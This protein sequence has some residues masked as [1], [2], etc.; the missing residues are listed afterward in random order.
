[1]PED[2]NA[3]IEKI[4]TEGVDAAKESAAK[5][6]AEAKNQ[7]RRILEKA[8][9]DAESVITEAKNETARARQATKA[10]LKQAA[11]D[12]IINLRQEI[13]A[14]LGRL[15]NARVKEALSA[16]EVSKIISSF[17]KDLSGKERS[18]VI[19][20]LEKGLLGELKE[21]AKKGIVVRASDEISVGFTISFDAGKS[22]YDFTDKALAEYIGVY[23]KPKL[24]EIL[25]G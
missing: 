18:S 20:S 3:L 12:M 2:L 6:E 23:L 5:I 25:K 19:V 17:I 13:D 16:D 24:S 10:L 14:V 11:R 21:E 9:L 4:Q 15:V 7:A 8:K 1:M 22:Q